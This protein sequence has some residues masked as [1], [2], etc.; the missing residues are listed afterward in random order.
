MCTELKKRKQV[1]TDLSY[2]L[3]NHKS[4]G[5]H[6]SVLIGNS[7]KMW[8]EALRGLPISKSVYFLETKTDKR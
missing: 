4:G 7:V 2:I 8:N 6:Y 1:Q 3:L 5:K